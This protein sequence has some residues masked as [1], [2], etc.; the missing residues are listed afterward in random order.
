MNEV[1]TIVVDTQ[2]DSRLCRYFSESIDELRPITARLAQDFIELTGEGVLQINLTDS[3]VWIDEY[4]YVM[5]A[6]I[7]VLMHASTF[8][9]ETVERDIDDSMDGDHESALASAGWG[10]DEDYGG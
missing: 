5:T 1:Y 2:D 7:V 9:P 8:E 6:R 3:K 10:L 4:T